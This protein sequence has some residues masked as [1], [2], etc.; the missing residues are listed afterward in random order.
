MNW[1]GLEVKLGIW[2]EE[3]LAG[4]PTPHAAVVLELLRQ[5]VLK[6]GVVMLDLA[7]AT[8]SYLPDCGDWDD[9][10]R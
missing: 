4:T 10:I 1:E 5:V 8:A 2:D 3:L 6:E 9:Y 7:D